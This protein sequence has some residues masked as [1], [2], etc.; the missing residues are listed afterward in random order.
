MTP[1]ESPGGFA[2]A[3]FGNGSSGLNGIGSNVNVPRIAT[4]VGTLFYN[5]DKNEPGLSPATSFALNQMAPPAENLRAAEQRSANNTTPTN[6]G[7]ANREDSGYAG[8]GERPPISAGVLEN[9]SPT[10][11]TWLR[12]HAFPAPAPGPNGK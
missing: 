11:R 2:S 7:S 8:S 9:F 10:T 5:W 1:V 4:D 6:N 12:Q 3:L